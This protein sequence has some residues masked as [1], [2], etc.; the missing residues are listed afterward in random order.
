M[1]LQLCHCPIAVAASASAP[2]L[3]WKGTAWSLHML[4]AP[5][6]NAFRGSLRISL[7][8]T[9]PADRRASCPL[10]EGHGSLFSHF[11]EKLTFSVIWKERKKEAT[12]KI[13]S[14]LV[15][16]AGCLSPCLLSNF[17][18]W[19]CWFFCVSL[20]I[21]IPLLV[22]TCSTTHTA[23]AWSKQAW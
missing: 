21:I 16:T 9:E 19:N 22:C 10:S 23:I 14:L 4:P 17:L 13:S 20:Y 7:S 1:R 5:V 3:S 8:L 12:R 11:F 18:T 2:R 15:V 6:L